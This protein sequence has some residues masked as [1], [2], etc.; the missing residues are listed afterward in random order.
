MVIVRLQEVVLD[1]ADPKYVS[2]S[3]YERCPSAG[4]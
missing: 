1:P 3:A 2:V 4:G